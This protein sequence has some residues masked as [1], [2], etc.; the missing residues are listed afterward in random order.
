MQTILQQIQEKQE[1]KYSPSTFLNW[2][3]NTLL[4]NTSF[5]CTYKTLH[6]WGKYEE[7]N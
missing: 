2:Y 4:N 6:L 1:Q 5:R 7:N 3:N